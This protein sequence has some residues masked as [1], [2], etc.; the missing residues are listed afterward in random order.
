MSEQGGKPPEFL[1]RD[2]YRLRRLMDAARILPIFAL[3]LL[4]LP[5]MRHDP[6]AEAPATA[7]EGVY[8]FLVWIGLILVAFFMSRGLRRTLDPPKGPPGAAPPPAARPG[9]SEAAPE[10][11]R[12]P[13]GE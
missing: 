5:L 13:A 10:I 4:L 6:G 1:A 7:G 3:V 2:S 8:L 9:G 12:D 11:R